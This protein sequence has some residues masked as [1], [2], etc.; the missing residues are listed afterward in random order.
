MMAQAPIRRHGKNLPLGRV[1]RRVCMRFEPR[2]LSSLLWRI[3]IV[4]AV[5]VVV[6]SV[7]KY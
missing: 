7:N 1:L 2:S 3:V 6:L 5:A 4:V